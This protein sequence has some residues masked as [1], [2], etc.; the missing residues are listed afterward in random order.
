MKRR[1][2][3]IKSGI[4]SASAITA[5]SSNAWI[6]KSAIPN[7]DQKR[8]IVI[9]LRGAVDGLNIVVPY[10]ETAYYQ[11]RPQIAIPQPGKEGGVI[12]LDGRFGLHPAL[13]SLMPQWQQNSLAFVHACGSPDPT[14]SHFDAQQY[15]ENAT[16]GDKH[17]QDGWMNRLL[18]VISQKTP[19]QAVSVGETT[20]EIFSGRMPVANIASGRNASRLPIDRPQLAAAFDQLYSGNDALSQTYRQGRIA[21]QAIINDLDS[22]MNLANNG[23]PLPNGFPS[24]AQR[25]AQLMLKDSRIELGFMALGGWD[26]HVNQGST[27]GQLAR[28]LKKLGSGL[29][30]LV[31]GLGSVYQNTTIVVMSEFG[32]TVKQND[33][34]GTDHGHGNV[35]WVLGG[36][37]RGGKVY[38]EWPGL[39]TGQLYQGRDLAITTDFRDVISTVLENH[40]HL[41]EA[42][43]NQVLPNYTSTQKVAL[44]VK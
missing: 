6:A 41:N 30:A 14:R 21:H 26:T 7:S 9:F 11:A 27:Q 42:K 17:T 2:F 43:L 3:L 13:A 28:N 22:E 18:G 35:M 32:R 33:D 10:S 39:S 20:P 40:L 4:F 16:P 36:K 44:I 38:G 15:M 31:K 25:L 1:D 23:A 29:A 8:L 37:I 34:S 12:D 5:V 19:I 24:D